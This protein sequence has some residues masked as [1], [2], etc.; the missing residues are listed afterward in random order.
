MKTD[1][2]SPYDT[3]SDISTAV[4]TPFDPMTKSPASISNSVPGGPYSPATN[5]GDITRIDN[6]SLGN[7]LI[8]PNM[9]IF[10]DYPGDINN[11]VFNEDSILHPD[12]F[13]PDI[14]TKNGIT[15]SN[16][17]HLQ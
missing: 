11:D 4:S 13:I 5:L 9:S 12:F 1:L 14:S 10:M 15:K 7:N 16:G 3:F 6:Y 8:D 2:P 17:D